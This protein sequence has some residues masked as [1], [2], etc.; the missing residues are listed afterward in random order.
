MLKFLYVILLALFSTMSARAAAAPLKVLVFSKTE[1]FRHASIP[2][3]ISALEELGALH[4]WDVDATE[5]ASQLNDNNLK[6]YDVV[7]WLNTSGNILDLR[8]KA[9]YER[10]QQSHKGTVAIH[11]AGTDTER[12]GWPW[13]RKMASVLFSGHPRIQK[14]T[15]LVQDQTH[16]A[17]FGLPLRWEH[18][19]EW[20]SFASDP[21]L[22]PDVH[23]LASVDEET[24]DPGEF[25]LGRGAKDHPIA[26]YKQY[27][28]GR[29]FYTSLGHTY[30]DYQSDRYFRAL[31]TG[32][33]E[34][35]GGRRSDHV[36]RDTDDAALIFK[37]FDGTSPNGV[38]DR[39][40]PPQP[41][42]FKYAVKADALEMYA[43]TPLNQHLVRE[44]A[45]IDPSRPY[46]IEGKFVIPTLG[47]DANSFC[48]NLN[49]A[50]PD[51][52]VSNVNTWSLN[53]DLHQE[54]GAVIKFMGFVKGRFTEIGQVETSWGAAGTEYWFRMY[55]N[56]DYDGRYESKRVSM[57]VMKG[58]TQLEKLMVDYSSFPYQPDGA[59]SVRLGVN[60]HE[61]DWVLRDLKVYYLD[62]PQRLK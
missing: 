62:V 57:F 27:D 15:I 30:E 48:V 39:Q 40:A 26:W 59:K 33:I 2:A 4:G 19:E 11:E 17:S 23:V 3:G 14:A 10:F 36:V 37:E 46:A 50:G 45:P 7:V 54:G 28:G 24:Y 41:P 16:P 6:R 31:I 58:D 13:Y 61:A 56:A 21:R 35:A 34:W 22:D 18:V 5:D 1:A 20:Y 52:D 44:G 51:G 47:D 55:V 49:V 53:V 12:D 42:N 32:A 38:W 8:Q 29:Y 9:A 43:N 60:T 25:A